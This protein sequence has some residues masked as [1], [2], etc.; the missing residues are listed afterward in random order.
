MLGCVRSRSRVCIHARARV[1]A[2]VFE[3]YADEQQLIHEDFIQRAEFGFSFVCIHVKGGFSSSTPQCLYIICTQ[4]K[5]GVD[6]RT[7]CAMINTRLP[8]RRHVYFIFY[9]FVLLDNNASLSS[10][11]LGR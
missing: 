2:C 4:H 11:R 6:V 3:N 5:K 10:Y 9:L 1:F 7:S 8:T